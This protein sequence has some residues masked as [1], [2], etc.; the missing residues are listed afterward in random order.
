MQ[1]ILLSIALLLSF[2]GLGAQTPVTWT[3][4]QKHL[5]GDEFELTYTASVQEGWYIYSQYLPSE[6]GPVATSFTYDSK[7]FQAIGKNVESGNKIEG[8]DD[9][10]DMNIIKFKGP[11]VL[12]KQ[13]VKVTDY[14]KPIVGYLTFMTCDKS[15]CLP[16]TDV[17][18]SFKI[19]KPAAATTTPNGVEDGKTQDPKTLDPDTPV[20][21]DGDTSASVN[22]S[23]DT[24][25]ASKG[26]ESSTVADKA[27]LRRPNLDVK[28]PAGLCGEQKEADKSLW[29][30]FIAGFIGGLV[31]LLTPCVFPMLPLTVSFFTKRSKTKAEGLK[32][33]IIYGL[34]IIVIYV[35]IGLLITLSLGENAL[36][37]LSTNWIMNTAFFLIF[38]VFA[39]SFF[40]YFEIT[41]PSSWTNSSDRAAARGGLLGIFFMAFTL[42]L[43]SFSCTGPIIGTLL[44]ET[45]R[46]SILGPAIG[47][48]GFSTALALPFAL[49]AA[50]PGWLNSLPKSGGWM[51]DLKVVL[52]FVEIA[53]AFKFLSVADLTEHWGILKYE[54]F[55]AIWVLCALGIALYMLGIL[56]FK[57]G[58]PKAITPTRWIIAG[59]STALA[60][61]FALS[62]RYDSDLKT[63][64][65]VNILSGLAPPACNSYVYPCDC[66][67]GLNCFHDYFEALE[68][69]KSVNKPLFVDFT[70]HGCVNC[71]KMEDY[72][73]P[74]PEVYNMLKDD[75]VVV[76]LYVDD[77]EK[78]PEVIVTP[79]G[80]K[81][82]TVGSLWAEFEI[83]NINQISQ[84]YY[85]LLNTDERVLNTPVAYT[86]DAKTYADFLRCGLE[87]FKKLQGQ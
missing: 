11:K 3:F 15:R 69:A 82:R 34:S 41:L 8:Y 2:I 25:S 79:E 19:A 81:L 63:Y 48:L 86:P 13:K 50:F 20:S 80:K 24:S 23:T 62:F 45:S 75:Y 44:V 66:P 38:I 12:F 54:T 6:D 46:T 33:A 21:S 61:Y 10:F 14:S 37:M 71:R 72:V 65:P 59:V 78:L 26:T 18:F 60:I 35:G 58:K 67:L 84:P 1:R 22:N 28:N 77:R 57:Y 31:A 68:Y 52:G 16:P 76:S 64:R 74:N 56:R 83:Q 7:N 70:G 43:V 49:F 17:D 29:L 39:I 32:N 87:N 85:L 9:L 42:S 47:M 53:L 40:G 73:W 30:I 51:N 55:V 27:N 4:E 36:N 5:S